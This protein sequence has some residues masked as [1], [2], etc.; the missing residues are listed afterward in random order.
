MIHSK[1]T[2]REIIA[3]MQFTGFTRQESLDYFND[4]IERDNKMII[5]REQESKLPDQLTISFNL[6]PLY[7]T[8]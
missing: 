4:L 8:N 5:S 6:G 3:I 2:E 7:L 1:F